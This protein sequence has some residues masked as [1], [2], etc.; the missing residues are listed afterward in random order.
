MK[1]LKLLV[2]AMLVLLAFPCTASGPAPGKITVFAA[3]SLKE[4]LDALGARWKQRGGHEVVIAYAAS[5]A[6]AKQI[7]QQA[8]ADIFISADREWMDY[9][10][11]RGLVVASSRFDLAGNRLVL[12]APATSALATLSLAS[13]QP[14]LAVL[15]RDGRLAVAETVAVPAGRY[16]R[17]AL[18]RRGLWRA[19]ETRLAQAGNVRAAMAF[20]ARGEAPLGIV[21]FTDAKAEPK[22]RVVAT[23]DP[24]DHAAI[25][26]PAARVSGSRAAQADGFLAFLRSREARRVLRRAGFT[27]P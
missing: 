1:L 20:V 22:V 10:Q 23:F 6:L 14:M 19:V 27:M 8:P 2:A 3:A 18:E 17:E 24:R 26:Y 9:L 5:S 11:V 25:V 13:P 16:A 15:G 4:S 7:E 21:Y 12:V